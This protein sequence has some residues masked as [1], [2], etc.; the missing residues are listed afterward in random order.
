[1]SVTLEL[2]AAARARGL[3]SAFVATGQTGIA[4]AGWA[5]STM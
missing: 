4:I 3:Q 1:M 2:D 5:P